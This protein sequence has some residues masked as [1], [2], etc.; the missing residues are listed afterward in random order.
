MV[1]E[2]PVSQ[3]ATRMKIERF[4]DI[5]SW[6]LAR[7]L[8]NQVHGLATASPLAKDFTLKDQMLRSLGSV[9]DN[10]A[11]GFDGGSNREFIRFLQY[12]KRSCFEL[13]SQCYRCLDQRLCTESQFQEVFA[14]ASLTRNK[15]GAFI[16]YLGQHLDRKPGPSN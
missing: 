5:E 14:T 6:Q 16:R 12:A 3:A 11:E 9:M 13:Q 4:E 7:S 2:F 10:I 15:I 1:D 8:C